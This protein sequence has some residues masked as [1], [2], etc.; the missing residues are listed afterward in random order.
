MTTQ[1]A[2]SAFAQPWPT[3]TVARY[4]NL[5]GATVD[6]TTSHATGK[7]HALCGGCPWIE[8]GSTPGYIHDQ[9]Q[10]HAASCRALPRPTTGGNH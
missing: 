6:I 3:G 4:L 5:A 7:T 8:D 10:G 9:A 1:T 2:P